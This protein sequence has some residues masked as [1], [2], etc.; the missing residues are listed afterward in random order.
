MEKQTNIIASPC[1]HEETDLTIEGQNDCQGDQ[2]SV[3]EPN[4]VS[5]Q[6]QE[7]TTEGEKISQIETHDKA[8]T[9][10]DSVMTLSVYISVKRTIIG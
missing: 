3:T 8:I 6:V 5:S 9:D 4:Y 2:I 1:D 7:E 10:K